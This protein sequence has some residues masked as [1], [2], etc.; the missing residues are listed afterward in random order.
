MDHQASERAEILER[1]LSEARQREAAYREW[2][3]QT[4]QRTQRLREHT[5][6]LLDTLGKRPPRQRDLMRT[7]TD[8]A[9]ISSR[10]LAVARTSLWLFD[11]AGEQLQCKL[12][13]A[14]EAQRP[15]PP[16]GQSVE[17][18]VNLALPTSAS[19]EYFRAIG[20]NGVVAVEDV[21]NDPRTRGLEAYLQRHGVTALLDIS[22]AVPGELMGVVC[23]EHVG[24][25]RAWHPEEID[26][27]THVSN[28]IALALEVER[29]QLAEAKAVSAEARYRYLV[30]SLPVTVYSFDAFSQRIEY[31]SPQIRELGSLSAEEWL[32]RG[33][34]AWLAAVHEDDRALVQERFTP[35]GVDRVATEIEYRLQLPAAGVRYVRDQCR[36][37]RN[38]AGEPV[39]IQ[40]VLADITEQRKSQERAAELERRLSALLQNVDLI[41]M[42]L[43]ARG[44]FEFVN[45]CF[46][47]ATGYS[48]ADVLG[49]DSFELLLPEG[50]AAEARERYQ[51]EL[52]AERFENEIVGRTGE[53]RRVVWTRVPLRADD[54]SP[55]GSCSLGLDISE[56]VQR[57]AERLQQ[58]K[59]ESLG[60]LSAGVAHDFNNLL[61]VMT[62]QTEQ[63][64]N[65]VSREPD[66]RAVDVLQQSLRQAG[67]LTR[68]LLVYARREPVRPTALEIDPLIEQV[69]PLL[70]AM[71]AE[72]VRLTTSLHAPAAQVVIDPAQLRQLLLNLTSNAVDATRNH[73]R[74]VRISTALEFV[75]QALSR[76][77]VD[78][79]AGRYLVIAVS[80]DGRG[81]DPHTLACVFEPF[82][83]TKQQGRG[84]GLGLSMCQS[85][86]ERAGGF[87]RVE[88]ELGLGTTCRAY[89]PLHSSGELLRDQAKTPSAKPDRDTRVLVVEDE[90]LVR[91][92]LAAVL[93]ELVPRVETVG[94]LAEA[95]RIVATERIDLLVTD[96]TLPDGSGRTLARSV[97]AVRPET[98]VLLVSGAPEDPQDFDAILH[99]PFTREGLLSAV[100]RLLKS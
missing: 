64:G 8:T 11:A 30:E 33:V 48:S 24:G 31:L 44:K 46:E 95:T 39:A 28:L 17:P 35:Q 85:I 47:R 10:A 73:G 89:L 78:P 50:E 99:K 77:R 15:A 9:R 60:Q 72:D 83:T 18:T 69:T 87:M 71:G 16:P 61:T 54:G 26:F 29:R 56:R 38:H 41:A 75:D 82:F 98:R 13:L 55:A 40:G 37:V 65:A 96:G 21:T 92:L 58:T 70:A 51:R 23:H 27:A 22:I 2:L 81:M 62:V 74:E 52:S 91:R 5:S 7:L 49:R 42:I 6:A 93:E 94:T 57:E 1:E 79:R 32:A 25:P 68:S 80:D 3:S 100:K 84:T 45:A 76:E 14:D 36:V 20:N 43:D 12:L 34:P 59:L 19:P 86:V 4:A 97:R 67:D 66:R 53:R 90:P 88:S 63:L